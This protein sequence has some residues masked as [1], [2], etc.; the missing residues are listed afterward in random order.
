[1]DRRR[2]GAFGFSNGGFTVLVAAGGVPD[3]SRIAV[4]CDA[5]N[6]HDLCTALHAAG[7]SLPQG[8]SVPSNPWRADPRIRA[9]VVAAPAFGFTFASAGLAA[10]HMPVQLWGS[11]EDHH[12]PRP[13]YE[14]AVS[15]ALPEPPEFH[16]V[17]NAGHYAF[18]PPCSPH[19]ASHAPQICDDAPG[20]DRLAFHRAFN[21]QVVAFFERTLR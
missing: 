21:S 16:E 5:N 12:Q 6:G 13:W 9:I 17:A 15:A 10:V 1:L 14:D 8:I 18:L 3:L 4:Y 11:R 2:I 19:L 20:F 7:V